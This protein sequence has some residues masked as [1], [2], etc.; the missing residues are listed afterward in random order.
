MKEKVI[1]M[2]F[3]SRPVKFWLAL[4]VTVAGLLAPVGHAQSTLP[5]FPG[6]QGFGSK[7]RH[8][9]AGGAAPTVY[10]VTNL[11]DS[12]AG[13]LRAAL[14][15][16][17]PRIVIFEV[18]GYISL[19]SNIGIKNPYLYVAGET[20]PSPGI[21]LRNDYIYVATHDVVIRHL[22]VRSSNVGGST[23]LGGRGGL[24]IEQGA[25]NVVI[26]HCSVS[27]HTDDGLSTF[28]NTTRD[29]TY[30]NCIVSEGLYVDYY[31]SGSGALVAVGGAGKLERISYIRNLSAH[32]ARRNGGQVYQQTVTALINNVNY[33]WAGWASTFFVGTADNG[34]AAPRLF[35][36][37]R[38]PIHS[39][40]KR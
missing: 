17:G 26:D 36:Y 1:G 22:R 6:A 33:N 10:R 23:P 39:R 9:Y 30:S 27:W 15:A 14:T 5:A 11:N 28:H 20:A 29:S 12:G 13:S 2:W 40:R 18:S 25:Y 31:N 4:L 21:T 3:Q 24:S 38:Q 35:G 34:P 19:S 37:S 32:T 8:A 16:A 7:T